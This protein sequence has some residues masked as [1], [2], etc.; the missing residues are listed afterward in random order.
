MT[1]VCRLCFPA[2]GCAGAFKEIG[3]ALRGVRPIFGPLDVWTTLL[4]LLCLLL[5][6][7]LWLLHLQVRSNF[8]SKYIQML[9]QNC[10]KILIGVSILS[11]SGDLCKAR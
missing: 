7:S 1:S 4:P 10:G 9:S 6:K 8:K 2:N 3:D 11:S 5:C